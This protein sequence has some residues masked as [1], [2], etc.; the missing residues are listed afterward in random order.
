MPRVT[1]LVTESQDWDPGL[2]IFSYMLSLLKSAAVQMVYYTG[3]CFPLGTDERRRI[4]RVVLSELN[5]PSANE[6][7]RLIRFHNHSL[8]LT[9]HFLPH[10]LLSLLTSLHC[11]VQYPLLSLNLSPHAY[12]L[13]TKPD[14]LHSL[15]ARDCTQLDGVESLKLCL[16]LHLVVSRYLFYDGKV[17]TW[18][19]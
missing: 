6:N 5:V 12:V 19:V 11:D 7:E 1:E 13:I 16:C 3:I 17:A 15:I 2:H 14:L 4:F 8:R 9:L 10:Q 18:R